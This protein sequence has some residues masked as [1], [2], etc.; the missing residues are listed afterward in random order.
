VQ[1]IGGAIE[2]GGQTYEDMRKA[3]P[4]SPVWAVLEAYPTAVLVVAYA[5]AD[6]PMV[7]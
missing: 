5:I 2:R 6:R 1:V 3:A 4:D 7:H